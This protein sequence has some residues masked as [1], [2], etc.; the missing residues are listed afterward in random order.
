M[1]KIKILQVDLLNFKGFSELHVSF[2]GK[3]A[4]VLGGLNGYGKTTLFD[5]LE[6]LFT[7]SIKRMEGYSEYHDNRNAMGQDS[8]PLVY[9][10]NFSK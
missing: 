5:A 4:V 8:L 2:E 6:L 3:D 1:R 10:K 7:G 9:S